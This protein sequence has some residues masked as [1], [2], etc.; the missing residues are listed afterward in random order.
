M[1]T[2]GRPNRQ[3]FGAAGVPF[4]AL[5]TLSERYW[6]RRLGRAAASV[7]GVALGVAL[8]VAVIAVNQAVLRTYAVWVD[9]LSGG[10]H[11]EVRAIETSGMP[12]ELLDVVR[13]TPGV[14]AAG[15]VVEQRSYLFTETAQS[16]VVVRGIDSEV[17]RLTRPVRMSAGRPLEPGDDTGTVLSAATAAELSVGVGENVS[18]LSADGLLDLHVVGVYD[19]LDVGS[20]V[21]DRSALIPL[22]TAQSAFMNGRDVI[23]QVDVL[24]AAGSDLVELH[25]SLSGLVEPLALVRKPSDELQ[26]LSA[27]TKGLRSLL[28]LAGVMALVA[29]V[30]LIG[31]NLAAG[32]DERRRDLKVVRALGLSRRVGAAWFLAEAALMGGIGSVLG[33]LVGALGAG[34]LL[35]RLPSDLIAQVDGVNVSVGVDLVAASAG[36][37][38][39]L[40]VTLFVALPLAL[41]ANAGIDPVPAGGSDQ[42]ALRGRL[43]TESNNGFW[44]PNLLRTATAALAIPAAYALW[45]WLRVDGA[46]WTGTVQATAVMLFVLLLAVALLR[47]LPLLFDSLSEGVRHLAAAPLWLRLATDSLRRHAKRTGATA[48]SLSITLASLI[49]VYGA[50]ESYRYSLESWLDAAVNWDLLVTSGTQSGAASQPLPGAAVAVLAQVPGVADVVPERSVTVAAGGR[51]VALVA[52]DTTAS[53]PSRR[54]EGV[55]A[56]SGERVGAVEEPDLMTA[57]AGGGVALSPALAARLGLAPGEALNLWTPRGDRGFVVVALV[58]DGAN[59]SPGAYLDL[60]VY[61]EA[62]EDG[63]VDELGVQLTPGAD[64]ATTMQAMAS[65]LGDLLGERYPVRLVSASAFRQDMLDGVGAAFAVV[66]ALVLL[67]VLVALAGLLNAMLIGFWQ[68]RNQLGLLRALGA[69][70]TML[71]RTLA[72]EALLTTFAG[73]TAG[74]L[75][76]TLLSVALLRGLEPA[77][78]LL[79]T[80]SLPLDAY[81]TVAAL[82]LVVTL[83]GGTLLLGRARATPVAA[84]VRGE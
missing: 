63:A 34:A 70:A 29:A 4:V 37:G 51:A 33:G 52:F 59:E 22:G 81:L 49:G 20:L 55:V 54:L 8:V 11:L 15:G 45:R 79:L 47:S 2:R 64:A 69:P 23:S 76:G 39:G 21:R 41:R 14:A 71:V 5:A 6:R 26:D 84:V 50:A 80:W 13:A 53:R 9:A 31:N 36:A 12:V 58:E 16:A 18:L 67:A 3:R 60:G 66:R 19:A 75:L 57:L 82:M 42:W 68:L 61:A 46:V 83:L 28:L 35:K 17:L 78:G 74:V 43:P 10:R 27:T 38:V 65:A 48:V 40:L 44:G 7:L 72:A 62:F 73:V 32:V 77:S 30:F 25:R 1:D 24:P 56:P